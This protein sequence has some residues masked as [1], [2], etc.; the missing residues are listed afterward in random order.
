MHLAARKSKLLAPSPSAALS[1][2]VILRLVGSG[3]WGL[4]STMSHSEK[5]LWPI[6]LRDAELFQDHASLRGYVRDAELFQAQGA[7]LL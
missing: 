1:E 6:Y 4:P 7:G 2:D 3:G 5:Y